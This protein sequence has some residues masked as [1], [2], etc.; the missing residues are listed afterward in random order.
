MESKDADYKHSQE[1]KSSRKKVDL[2]G[3]ELETYHSRA[4]NEMK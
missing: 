1:E 4:T 2:T 3:M